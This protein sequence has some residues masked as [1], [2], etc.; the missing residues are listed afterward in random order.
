MIETLAEVVTSLSLS[1]SFLSLIW[2]A[3]RDKK[4]ASPFGI[5]GVLIFA[6]TLWHFVSGAHV[7]Y[8]AHEIITG[9]F[10]I[11]TCIMNVG[12]IHYIKVRVNVGFNRRKH[13]IEFEG[14]ER[15]KSNKN[16]HAKHVKS[17]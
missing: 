1:L 15:R 17:R 2:I 11:A 13:Q 8:G 12:C 9:L 5:F 16:I 3:R 6:Y 14:Q 4:I 7:G 10:V